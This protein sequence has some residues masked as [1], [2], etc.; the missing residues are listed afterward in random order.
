MYIYL[1]LTNHIT[2]FLYLHLISQSY[3]SICIPTSH[4]PIFCNIRNICESSTPSVEKENAE[5]FNIRSLKSSDW[6][7]Y[8]DISDQK[9]RY[10]QIPACANCQNVHCKDTNHVTNID[11]YATNILEILD[12][13]IKSVT[14]KNSKSN[15]RPKVVP[16]WSE[17]VKPFREDAM[18]WH[19]VWKSSGKPLN[20][21]IHHTVKR[22]RNL[23]HYAI[24]KCKKSVEQIKKNKLSLMNFVKYDMLKGISHRQSMAVTT[25]LMNLQMF[26]RNCITR[27]K[28][29]SEL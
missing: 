24:R 9:L 14:M 10:V 23:Y 27:L 3:Y 16:G 29:K 13:S 15:G 21:S 25:Y 26:T 20:N 12:T 4:S 1:S 2:V 19:A 18:F 7:Q 22:T 5:R 17:A 11:D 6:D 8:V 28:I